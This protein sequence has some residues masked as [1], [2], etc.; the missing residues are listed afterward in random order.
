MIAALVNWNVL[1]SRA[2]AVGARNS[3][4]HER[5]RESHC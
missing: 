1:K 4:G 2:E 5:E 3:G